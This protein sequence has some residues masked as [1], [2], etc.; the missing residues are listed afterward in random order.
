MKVAL[1]I[2]ATKFTD[3]DEQLGNFISKNNDIEFFIPKEDF[4]KFY[5]DGVKLLTDLNEID[6]IFSI[7]GDGTILS[8]IRRT[9]FSNKPVLGLKFGNLGFLTA[10]NFDEFLN[11]KEEI[12]NGKFE[13]EK[14]F[15]LEIEK[16][17][18]NGLSVFNDFALNDVV[19]EREDIARMSV[20]EVFVEDEFFT[21]YHSNG[22]IVSSPT[23]STAYN[24]SAGGPIVYPDSNSLIL[25]PI[26]PHSL[27]QR[28]VIISNKTVEL[29]LIGRV[30]VSAITLDG[31]RELT[32]VVG[33]KI[34]CKMSKKHI[35]LIKLEGE[36]FPSILRQKLGW[37]L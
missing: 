33:E 13:I 26:C 10:I 25:T 6:L 29:S 37:G 5:F 27:S 31:Q 30:E 9:K 15:L 24:L 20:I 34:R 1:Y 14:R 36:S 2:N 21:K 12:K 17:D 32:I 16:I 8:T 35:N 7:G 18:K 4:D 19:L 22:V 11:F 3:K 28:P 23:G